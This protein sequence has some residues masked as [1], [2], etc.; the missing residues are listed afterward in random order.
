M[1]KLSIS[2][3]TDFQIGHAQDL[4]A[5]TGCT[6]VICQ[7]GAVAGVDVR[8]GAPGTRETDLLDPR[9]TMEQ[10]HAIFLAGGSAFG[11]EV[12]SGIMKWLEE[13]Q[14][15]F[16]T[17]IA[18][19][20]IVPGA[21]LFDLGIG[22]ANVRPDSMMGYQAAKN[23]WEQKADIA[24]GNVG[25]GTGATVGKLLGSD[26]MM[27]SGIGYAGFQ[28]GDIQVAAL[29]AVNAVGDVFDPDANKQ[30][31]GLYDRD[32]QQLLQTNEVFLQQ[33]S[34]VKNKTDQQGVNTTI[35]I[36]M[37]NAKL[38]KAQINKLASIGH[39]G[40][41]RTIQPAHTSMDGDTLFAMSSSMVE[42]PLDLVG[43]IG[44]KAVE[45]AILEAIKQADSIEN[46]PAYKSLS[47]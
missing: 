47:K 16:D 18:K 6:T 23:A 17:G 29:V 21:I 38:S 45:L 14:V 31:A 24:L 1:K 28:I 36:M 12:G 10:V 33:F 39:N 15:G 4:D 37:T 19:V 41:A 8:G 34:H 30:L 3:L 11:L 32:Q 2:E 9:N 13:K 42:A 26:Y 25:A 46:I 7:K 20:P 27:K 44:T 5:L 43:I 22:H 35:G 40:I